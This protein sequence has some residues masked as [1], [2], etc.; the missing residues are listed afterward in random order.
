[1]TTLSVFVPAC[2]CCEKAAGNPFLPP[3]SLHLGQVNPYFSQSN[4]AQI[5]STLTRM[6]ASCKCVEI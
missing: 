2:V 3:F 1:M 5:L 4:K 6:D